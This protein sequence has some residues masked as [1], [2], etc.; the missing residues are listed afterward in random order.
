MGFLL[1]LLE[2]PA[3][4]KADLDSLRTS[5]DSK[6]NMKWHCKGKTEE[7]FKGAKLAGNVRATLEA[8]QELH[9]T[10]DNVHIGANYHMIVPNGTIFAWTHESK[11]V[12]EQAVVEIKRLLEEMQ[13][14]Q[15]REFEFY[16]EY[17]LTQTIVA[18][19][20]SRASAWQAGEDIR[21]RDR[22]GR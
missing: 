6:V 7:C 19:P 12:A 17:N 8:L 21:Y 14:L 10:V 11:R 5:K 18:D 4:L 13:E 3:Q 9:C 1:V 22:D 15:L 16:I 2:P 20:Q